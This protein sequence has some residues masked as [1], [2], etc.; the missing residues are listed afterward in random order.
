MARDHT[1]RRRDKG[2]RSPF[3]NAL[4]EELVQRGENETPNKALRHT[5]FALAVGCLETG[6]PNIG[7]KLRDRVLKHLREITPPRNFQEARALAAAGEVALG[8]LEYGKLRRAESKVNTVAAC[9][10]TIALIGTRRATRMLEGDNGY[11][12]DARVTVVAEI[13]RCP[14][15]D[16]RN[17]PAVCRYFGHRTGFPRSLLPYLD[18]MLRTLSEKVTTIYL[19]HREKLSQLSLPDLPNLKSLD[20]SECGGLTQL[21]LHELPNLR[22]LNLGSCN[23]LKQLSLPDLPNLKSLNLSWCDGLRQLSLHELPNLKSL[24]LS[25]CYGLRQLSLAELPILQSLD[26]SGCKSL[27]QLSLPELPNLQSLDLSRCHRLMQLSLPN[28][29]DLQSLS[30]TSCLWPTQLSLASLPNLH[31]LDVSWSSDL[32]Q[33]SL[34]NLPNLQSLNLGWCRGLRQ[35][36]LPELPSLQSLALSE[37]THLTK[38]VL[39]DLPKLRTL[40]LR[41]CPRL[42]GGLPVLPNV[43][44]RR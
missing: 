3:G 44:V 23:G 42:K 26:L 15:I 32:T 30:L 43:R 22:L 37:C 6:G 1:A 41:G 17:V 16:L 4:V 9:A 7:T 25:W 8:Y 29:P 12:S 2:W 35:L 40:D 38:L 28:L 27:K 5:C 10:R 20:L 21:S 18:E 39:P 19:R 11:G 13:L 24:N 36:S 33:L 31:L 34:P 14:S